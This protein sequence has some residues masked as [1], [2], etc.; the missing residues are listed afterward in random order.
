MVTRRYGIAWKSKIQWAEYRLD[1]NT[2]K[3]IR[4]PNY[5]KWIFWSIWSSNL[6]TQSHTPITFLIKIQC[7][8][9]ICIHKS[10]I[11][12]LLFFVCFQN[13]SSVDDGEYKCRANNNAHDQTSRD[14]RSYT[15]R[16]WCKWFPKY[17]FL[18]RQNSRLLYNLPLT[19]NTHHAHMHT[20]IYIYIQLCVC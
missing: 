2:C 18:S 14:E 9:I 12:H 13:I 11:S 7:K 1:Y 19:H 5:I 10:D 4:I 3:E 15:L 16:V 20:W 6:F 8:F 17:D